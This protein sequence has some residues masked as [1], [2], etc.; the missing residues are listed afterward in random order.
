MPN[1]RKLYKG[2]GLTRANGDQCTRE[3]LSQT[4]GEAG[5]SKN[6]STLFTRAHRPLS[7][8]HDVRRSNIMAARGRTWHQTQS[9]AHCPS[10]CFFFLA[11]SASRPEKRMRP[12]GRQMQGR[13]LSWHAHHANE[14]RFFHLMLTLFH[15][16]SCCRFDPHELGTARHGQNDSGGKRGDGDY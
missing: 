6:V 3:Q 9:E 15:L 14:T 12:R 5:I 7:P 1:S 13:S 8:Q 11:R 16:C 10:L 2:R 4:D